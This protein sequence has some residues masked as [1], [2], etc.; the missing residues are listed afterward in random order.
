MI[1]IDVATLNGLVEGYEDLDSN[2]VVSE[3]D[4]VKA[5]GKDRPIMGSHV[6]DLNKFATYLQNVTGRTVRALKDGDENYSKHVNYYLAF[7][8]KANAYHLEKIV[9]LGY[10]TEEYDSDSS[11]TIYVDE[12]D[13]AIG[14]TFSA[15][16]YSGCGNKADAKRY[17]ALSAEYACVMKDINAHWTSKNELEALSRKAELETKLTRLEKKLG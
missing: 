11:R 8:D 1:Q 10:S 7:S 17:A 6:E 16:H 5:R 3:G 15:G 4:S 14:L 2:G 9:K 12:K 13:E